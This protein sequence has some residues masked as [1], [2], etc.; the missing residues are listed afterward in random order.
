MEAVRKIIELYDWEAYVGITA[1]L[2][3]EGT[4][5]RLRNEYV[6]PAGRRWRGFH[7]VDAG[8]GHAVTL[9]L[10]CVLSQPPGQDVSDQS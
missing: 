2:F 3:A 7:V 10:T 8:E 1:I 5:C 9:P 6:N 4:W